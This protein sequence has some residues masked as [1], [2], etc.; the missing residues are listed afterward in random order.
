MSGGVVTLAVPCRTDEPALGRT[1]AAAWDAWQAAPGTTT[2]RLEVLVCLN[3]EAPAGPALEQLCGFAR[4][5]GVTVREVDLDATPA[6]SELAPGPAPEVVALRTRRRGKAPAWNALRHHAHGRTM[7]FTDADV[8]FA[9]D[10]FGLLLGALD[11]HPAAVLASGKT[12]CDARPTLF[13]GVMAAPYGVDFPNL[14][15]QLY[16]ARTDELPPRM[17]DNLLDPEHWLELTVGAERIVR[18]PGARVV[19]RLPA[20][21]RDFFRQRVRIEMAKV[22]L[23][24]EHPH[25]L[26]RGAVQPGPAAVLRALR[27]ADLLRLGAYLALRRAAHVVARRRYGSGRT[28]DTWPQAGSTK[29]WDTT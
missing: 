29:H 25:L 8:R 27:P 1:L 2:S 6:R 26:G 18:A 12:V 7:L 22:Q 16:A 19:I 9:P 14:S 3:G 20:T 4:P 17:P 28:A 11:E 13:E 23:A 24:A 15:P 10:A 21:L 5:L